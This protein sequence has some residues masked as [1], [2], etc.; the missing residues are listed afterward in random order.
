MTNAPVAVF[1][2]HN[3]TLLDVR[4]DGREGGRSFFERREAGHLDLPR[5]RDGG[6]AGG[7]FA[8][9]VPNDDHEYDRE[10]TA[11]GYEMD[12]PPAVDRERAR[13]FTYDALA[14]LH[15]IR[16]D[17]DGAV[18]IVGDAEALDAAL[19]SDA[20]AAIPHLE[21][22]EAVAPD[23]S[24]LDLLYAAGV[25]SIGPVWSR[26]NAFGHGVRFEYPGTPD[27]GP[28]LTDAGRDLVAACNDR[29]IVV[30]LAHL[31]AAGFEDVAALSTDP[32]VVSHGAVHAICPSSRN[33]TD[34]QLDAIAASGGLV[35]ITF[36]VGFLRPDG[37]SDPDTPIATLVDHVEYVADRVGV[38]HV[39]LGSDFDGATIPDP[40]GDA[41]GLSDV[42]A[43]IR[44]RGFDEDEV[45]KIARDN[46]LRVLG[47]TWA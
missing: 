42:L 1:D 19:D 44:D 36:A 35:G 17:S 47:E 28:G 38:D 34:E 45:E 37:E 30:D 22:A 39:A 46:W 11:E 23:L 32:L 27:T 40:I 9:F 10:P 8:V 6:L 15:R 12:L 7:L 20:L 16:A 14:R 18:R 5:A 25:R 2:G 29:G 3:D 43:A 4:A 26:P 31:N 33:L 21:G 24:N 13:A 41:T